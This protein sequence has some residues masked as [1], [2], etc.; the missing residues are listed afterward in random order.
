M[1]E[2]IRRLSE[3]DGLTQISNRL[4]LDAV[5]K[6]EIE[7]LSRSDSVCSVIILDID[8][9]KKV[10]D[11][12]GHLVGDEVLKDVADIIKKGVR[13][14]DTVGRWGG[15]EFM[16][17]MPVTEA[18]KG[19]V[20][21]EKLRNKISRHVFA[22]VGNLTA[23]FG[24]AESRGDLNAVELVAKADAAMYQAKDAGRNQVC[25]SPKSSN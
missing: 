8:F 18:S 25:K 9:F 5:L 3:T 16:V 2:E 19:M 21:A 12:Y 1:E 7:R 23:S 22:G 14:I 11:T 13:K 24:V 4:K 15:E 20:L 10:N 6:L 17:I